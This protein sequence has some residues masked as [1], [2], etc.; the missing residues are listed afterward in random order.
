[1]HS[2][3]SGTCGCLLWQELTVIGTNKLECK[4]QR[5]ACVHRDPGAFCQKGPGQLPC[6]PTFLASPEPP[7][8]AVH[9]LQKQ[10]GE[11]RTRGWTGRSAVEYEFRF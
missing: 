2:L 7:A 1:M 3:G 5:A 4:G 9:V 8:L 11:G 10:H 6:L